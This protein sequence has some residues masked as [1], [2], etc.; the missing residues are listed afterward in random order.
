MTATLR[1]RVQGGRLLLDE[2]IGLPEGTEVEL[3]PA[4]FD[5]DLD[6]EDR[7]L[8]DAAVERGAAEAE[9]G[10]TFPADEVLAE[11]AAQP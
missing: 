6:D 11:L 9:A 7:R 4:D 8:R 10:D 5:D 2:P 1:A 3:V